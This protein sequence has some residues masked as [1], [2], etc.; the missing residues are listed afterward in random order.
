MNEMILTN[1][2]LKI[3]KALINQFESNFELEKKKNEFEHILIDLIL[4]S[5]SWGVGGVLDQDGRVKL[6]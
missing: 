1:N 5:V 6:N 2:S 4:F 3:F